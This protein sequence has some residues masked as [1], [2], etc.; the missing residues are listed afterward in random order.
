MA[1]HLFICRVM[2]QGW[3]VP[4]ILGPLRPERSQGH[5]IVGMPQTEDVA[6]IKA[7]Q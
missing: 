6:C 2:P 3:V 5:V 1:K 7:A 4:E